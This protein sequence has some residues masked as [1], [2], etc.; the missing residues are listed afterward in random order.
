MVRVWEVPC[1][2]VR[3]VGLDAMVKSGATTVR[4]SVTEC[5]APGAFDVD[6]ARP[7]TV[8]V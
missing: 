1:A 3:D 4:V 7:V 5:V 6:P 8:M 2:T